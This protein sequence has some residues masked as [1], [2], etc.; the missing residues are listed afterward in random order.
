MSFSPSQS[1]V[2]PSHYLAMECLPVAFDRRGTNVFLSFAEFG[3]LATFTPNWRGLTQESA[4]WTLSK[5]IG[6]ISNL[7]LRTR[8]CYR[9]HIHL[10]II[11]AAGTAIFAHYNCD[12]GKI[13]GL[14]LLVT[15][16]GRSDLLFGER[17]G[18]MPHER[19]YH[20]WFYGRAEFTTL[21]HHV[22]VLLLRPPNKFP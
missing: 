15:K 9:H 8:D 7:F 13:Q 17:S 11:S 12:S 14:K 5:A 4:D 3:G 16:I 10:Y 6:W 2:F 20:S 21:W 19:L 18:L 22:I 1:S